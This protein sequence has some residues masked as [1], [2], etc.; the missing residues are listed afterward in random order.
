[1]KNLVFFMFSIFVVLSF[2]DTAE[3]QTKFKIGT[4][5]PNLKLPSIE[6]NQPLSIK[7]FRGRKVVLHIFASW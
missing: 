7:D 1:M 5:F 6:D 2:V 4:E 3:T